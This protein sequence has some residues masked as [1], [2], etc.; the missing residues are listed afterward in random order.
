MVSTSY[1]RV[2]L[3]I[4]EPFGTAHGRTGTASNVVVRIRSG[5]AVG[6]D[7]PERM[8]EKIVGGEI[9]LGAV[10]AGTGARHC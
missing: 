5:D 6:L 8:A 1:E 10:E 9:D 4:E 2:E 7:S 3:P